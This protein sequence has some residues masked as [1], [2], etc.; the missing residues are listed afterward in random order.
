MTLRL[1]RNICGLAGLGFALSACSL[2]SAFGSGADEDYSMGY[3]GGDYGNYAGDYSN[4][5]GQQMA[6]YSANGA[7]GTGAY[8]VGAHGIGG[9]CMGAHMHGQAYGSYQGQYS[10]GSARYGGGELRGYSGSVKKSRYG[11]YEY[12]GG[13]SAAM[14]GCGGGYYMIPTYQV[15]QQPAPAPAPVPAIPSVTIEEKTC[16]AGQ[17]KMANGDCAIMQTE[18]YEPPVTTGYVEPVT[19]PLD[20]YQPIR[21]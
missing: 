7:Y 13:S 17:Y 8:G 20:Y 21:K 18:Q 4:G 19:T 9:G 3:G 6:G 2:G 14:S 10:G 1:F 12:S 15:V 5:Y 11:S 16:P